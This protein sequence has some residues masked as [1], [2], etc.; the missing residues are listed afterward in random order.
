M[1]KRKY[2]RRQKPYRDDV[3]QLLGDMLIDDSRDGR[4]S[5][6][7]LENRLSYHLFRTLDAG[8]A[9]DQLAKSE[10]NRFLAAKRN[11]GEVEFP[12]RNEVVFVKD[13]APDQIDV[14]NERRLARILGELATRIRF[15]EE[16]DNVRE[17]DSAVR[18]ALLTLREQGCEVSPEVVLD[19]VKDDV[20]LVKLLKAA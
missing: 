9:F 2:E 6:K 4:I 1:S 5:K 10:V 14:I 13:L 19:Y 8:S 12:T 16:H 7:H 20:P 18:I 17:R 3:D 15:N 11:E